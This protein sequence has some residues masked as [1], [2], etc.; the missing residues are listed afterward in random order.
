M[1]KINSVAGR[2]IAVT[3]AGSGIGRATARLL[4]ERGAKVALSDRDAEGLAETSKLLGNY[5]HSTK[6]FDVTEPGA[7]ERWIDEAAEEFGG[8]DGIINNAGLSVVAPFEHCPEEDFQRVMDVNFDAVVRGCRA[9][10]PHV[11][12]RPHAWLV[13]ISSVFGMMGYPT[14]TAYNA[15]KYAVR[16]FSEALHLEM[17]ATRPNVQ[18][19]RVHPG[20]IKTRVAHNSKFIR[21][22]EDDD[23]ALSQNDPDGFVAA[24]QT[25]PEEAAETIVDGMERGDHRVLIGKDAKFIDWMTRLFPVNYWK[26]IGTFLSPSDDQK[27]KAAS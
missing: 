1:G 26:R 11:K 18:V 20:G 23:G 21:G 7:L 22:M 9:A 2:T 19:V 15:S 25:T 13:N 8:L 14:Q 12:D 5:P 24:A 10:M 6:V 4:V 17:Q 3:G 16:G 27:K